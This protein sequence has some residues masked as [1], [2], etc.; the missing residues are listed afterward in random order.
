LRIEP[1]TRLSVRV[2]VAQRAIELEPVVVTVLSDEAWRTRSRGTRINEILREEIQAGSDRHQ[3]LSDLLLEH[4]PGMRVREQVT[5]PGQNPCLEFRAPKTIQAPLRCHY[6]LIYLDG[7]RIHDPGFLLATM[8]LDEIH[9]LEVLAP[10]EAGARYGTGSG[11][12]VLRIDTRIGPELDVSEETRPADGFYPWE[13][14]TES[15]PAKRAFAAGL[16]GN[17]VGLGL[18]YLLA[19]RCMGLED[20]AYETF[21]T[22]RCSGWAT[23]G[24]HAAVVSL[25][26]LGASLGA[27]LGGR[28]ALSRG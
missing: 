1:G 28:T 22:A 27:R 11:W 10:S 18:S 3:S 16:L 9:R 4:V 8:S 13:L 2:S 24:A 21:S 7:L 19:R 25:P 5:R 14:E 15:H 26:V 23:A 6:P 17:S 12:G 20:L